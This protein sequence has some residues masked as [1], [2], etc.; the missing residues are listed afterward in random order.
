M[1]YS[2]VYNTGLPGM[3]SVSIDEANAWFIR[4]EEQLQKCVYF[5]ILFAICCHLI[6]RLIQY[7]SLYSAIFVATSAH[8]KPHKL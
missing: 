5:L 3:V 7:Q 8:D 1:D 2:F 6:C 4:R